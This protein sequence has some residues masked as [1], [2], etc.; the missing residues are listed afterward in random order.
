M[1]P[2]L[3]ALAITEKELERLT[4]CDVGPLF[5]GGILGGV[6]RPSIFQ[7]LQ[8][9]LAFCLTEVVVFLLV[10]AF[11]L[12]IGL[13]LMRDSSNGV[14]QV[15]GML[16]FLTVTLGMALMVMIA[17]NVYMWLRGKRLRSLMQ[18]LDEVDRYHAVIGAIA[19]LDQLEAVG[20]PQTVLSDANLSQTSLQNRTE[21][22]EAL[23]LTR[24]NLVAGLMTE[25]I[26]RDS[27]G[28]LA[29]RQELIAGIET[30]LVTLRA[31]E[32]KHQANEYGQVLN[33]ALQ[34]GIKVHQEIQQLSN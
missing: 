22:L 26:L 11:T 33:E 20:H 15:P 19:V 2:D 34:I 31:I 29:R 6:Y 10:F 17:W 12:P 27:R 21:V 32:V 23:R 7:T 13:S 25:K 14:N 28:L 9:S 4:G 30:N 1:R 24:D 16:Q 8:R 5:V 3:K 18:L